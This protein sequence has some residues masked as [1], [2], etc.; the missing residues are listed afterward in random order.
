MTHLSLDQLL[1][2]REPGLEPGLTAARAHLD[3][4]AD[5]QAEARR[6][7]QRSAR[8]R[9]LPSLRPAR[10]R[11]DVVRQQMKAERRRRRIRWGAVATAAIAAGV[12]VAVAVRHAERRTDMAELAI[13]SVR[14][15]SSELERLLQSY[16]PETRLTD[17]ATAIAA[18]QL[19]DQIARV[20]RQLELV[21][22]TPQGLEERQLQLQLWRQRVG[23]LDALVDVHLTRASQVGF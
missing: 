14:A 3:V 20:D 10:S 19:E 2:L 17:G 23:L 15:R 11:W 7:D 9:A 13:D 8:L 4:C 21:Q 5:C 16:D 6:L 12:L 1:A 22:V 18:G